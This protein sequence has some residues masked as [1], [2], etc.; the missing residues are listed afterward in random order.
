MAVLPWRVV[1]ARTRLV[2]GSTLSVVAGYHGVGGGVGRSTS[3]RR[4]RPHTNDGE[5][6]Q[7]G[8]CALTNCLQRLSTEQIRRKTGGEGWL[9][10]SGGSCQGSS[11]KAVTLADM[12]KPAST[13]MLDH[14]I[15]SEKHLMAQ[16][17]FRFSA[18]RVRGGVAEHSQTQQAIPKQQY[19]KTLLS[20]SI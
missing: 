3:I 6:S 20:M 13:C 7:G 11:C 1:V 17:I 15:I 4:Y 16:S 10:R 9:E 12:P 5:K 2:M 19:A 8:Q 14:P 18:T